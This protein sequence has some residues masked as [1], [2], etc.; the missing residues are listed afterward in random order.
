[1]KLEFVEINWTE[2][3]PKRMHG[4]PG[5]ECTKRALEVVL[6]GGHRVVILSTVRS[7]ASDLLRA[8]ANIAKANGF[9][10]S[11]MV[12][13]VCPC[14]AYGNPK[15]ECSCSM[16]KL[17]AH[18]RKVMPML[19]AADIVIETVEPLA[20]DTTR[21]NEHE[22]RIVARILE[23]R[24]APRLDTSVLPSDAE[25]LLRMAIKEYGTSRDKAV[26]VAATIARLD[27]CNRIEARHIAE[28]VQYQ[29]PAFTRWVDDFEEASA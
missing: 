21:T 8:A 28:A 3:S 6:A 4:I 12:V 29:H 11:G 18:A 1:M 23:A 2:S 7:P 14:G 5:N 20:R 25:E 26:A 13:P 19:K 27:G 22:D 9:P 17:K 10:F 15:V 24:K 16:A